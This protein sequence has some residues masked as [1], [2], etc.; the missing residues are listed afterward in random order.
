MHMV[1]R[2]MALQN[3]HVFLA[4]DLPYQLTDTCP[5]LSRKDSLPILRDPHYMQV[6]REDS[7]RTVSVFHA[8]I[9][10]TPSMLKPPPEGGGFNPPQRGQ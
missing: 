2:N 4:A 10:P 1:F 3:L 8:A 5:N 6:D 9:L 7:V